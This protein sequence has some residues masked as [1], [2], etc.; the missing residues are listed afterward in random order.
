[1]IEDGHDNRQTEA[2]IAKNCSD[3]TVVVLSYSVVNKAKL[4][5]LRMG[6][7]SLY[8]LHLFPDLD[9]N[10]ETKRVFLLGIK[11]IKRDISQ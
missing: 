6:H 9:G 11:M 5:H 3:T 2:N 1:M 7:L 10:K 4:G 8:K